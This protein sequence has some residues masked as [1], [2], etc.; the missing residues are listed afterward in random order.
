MA[1]PPASKQLDEFSAFFVIKQKTNEET[2]K[3]AK[4]AK[5]RP[6]RPN[7]LITDNLPLFSRERNRKLRWMAAKSRAADKVESEAL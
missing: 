6:M 1:P 7:V 5:N 3:N 2:A 4:N